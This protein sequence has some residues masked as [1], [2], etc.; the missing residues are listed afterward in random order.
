[1]K[2]KTIGY[3]QVLNYLDTLF[4]TFNKKPLHQSW[5]G[6]DH[7]DHQKGGEA[8]RDTQQQHKR[9]RPFLST[10][11]LQEDLFFEFLKDFQTASRNYAQKQIK[12]FKKQSLFQ[13]VCMSLY[14]YLY[15]SNEYIYI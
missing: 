2:G 7:L 6:D 3:F 12:W 11:S 10:Y 15:I 9:H 8:T 14:L 1:M 4:H 5:D 13:W